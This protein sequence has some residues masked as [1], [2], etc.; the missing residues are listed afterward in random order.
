[1]I[2]GTVSGSK[3]VAAHFRQVP[4]SVRQRLR[5]SI[6]QLIIKLQRKIIREKLSGQVLNVR[7]GTLR[8]SI[9]QHVID[10]PEGV[11][12]IAFSNLKYARRHEYGFTGTENV[13]AHMRMMKQAFG[14]PVKNPREVPVM[15]HKRQVDYKARSFMRTALREMEPEIIAQIERAVSM[16][17]H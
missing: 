14:R 2:E 3:E 17:L 13:R 5:V 8:R 4:E 6:G 7:S 16:G 15:T 1:M 9:D 12:G 11:A 10:L